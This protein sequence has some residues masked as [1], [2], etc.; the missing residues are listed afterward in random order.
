MLCCQA[1]GLPPFAIASCLLLRVSV[2]FAFADSLLC[3]LLALHLPWPAARAGGPAF[4]GDSLQQLLLP[5]KLLPLG[6]S[7]LGLF[8]TAVRCAT[9]STTANRPLP[10]WRA[11][12]PCTCGV[13]T[14]SRTAPPC[15]LLLQ[16]LSNLPE[17]TPGVQQGTAKLLAEQVGVQTNQVQLATPSFPV[18]SEV[19]VTGAC[20][21]ACTLPVSPLPALPPSLVYCPSGWILTAIVCSC[22]SLPRLMDGTAGVPAGYDTDVTMSLVYYLEVDK[23][24]GLRLAGWLAGWLAERWV[25]WIVGRCTSWQAT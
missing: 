17:Y 14:T 5:G 20:A 24:G 15:C 12:H 2:K 7:V 1:G 21:C 22:C 25:W 16:V 11:I 23:S 8:G 13:P 19:T 18:T 3:C 10:P 9:W 6:A 4:C